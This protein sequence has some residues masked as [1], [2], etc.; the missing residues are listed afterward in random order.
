VAERRHGSCE[1]SGFERRITG[2]TH[3][4]GR[5]RDPVPARCTLGLGPEMRAI[6]AVGQS[7]DLF[8]RPGQNERRRRGTAQVLQPMLQPL[9]RFGGPGPILRASAQASRAN[10]EPS[11]IMSEFFVRF[12]RRRHRP[13]ADIR[14]NPSLHDRHRYPARTAVPH[15]MPWTRTSA[16]PRCTPRV[17]SSEW[18]T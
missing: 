3:I 5:H 2:T 16:S 7:G 1:C 18:M 12:R 15:R 13:C 8:F 10:I 6:R 4:T 11:R 17:V 14:C 9:R